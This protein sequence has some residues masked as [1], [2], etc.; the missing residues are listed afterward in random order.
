MEEAGLSGAT[1]ASAMFYILSKLLGFFAHPSNAIIVGGIVGVLLLRTRFAR[2]A[3]TLVVGSLLLLAV[4]GFSP[5]GNAL[6][7]TL[8]QRFPP[9]DASRGPPHGVVI[10]GGAITPDVADA[11]NAAAVNE[12]GERL[13]AIVELARRYPEA[14]IIFSGGPGGLIR[15]IVPEADVALVLLEKLGIP[16]ARIE[17]ESRSRNTVENAIFSKEIAAPKPGD[18]WLLLTS[19]HHMPRA[20]GVFRKAGFAV[21][22]YPVDWRTRGEVDTT[23]WFM[24][25]A[26][27]L[28]RTDTAMHEWVGLVV[29]R[30]TGKTLELFPGPHD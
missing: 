9:W 10:L 16:R 22:A 17:T 2:T 8:E 24:T 3:W 5:V 28:K 20:I 6:I 27:G 26:D 7:L 15:D 21:E 13:I 30:L 4:F 29:Y 11:R 1:W 19:A 18:R 23:R 25:V 14:R 12:A